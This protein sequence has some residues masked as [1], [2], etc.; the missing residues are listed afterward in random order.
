MALW[1]GDAPPATLGT[2]FSVAQG[3]KSGKTCTWRRLSARCRL[4]SLDSPA[5]KLYIAAKEHNER[6][7]HD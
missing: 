5:M 3:K 2:A 4:A 1:G 7:Y 6:D